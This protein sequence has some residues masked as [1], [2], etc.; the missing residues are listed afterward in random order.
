MPTAAEAAVTG[1]ERGQDGVAA[2][3]LLAHAWLERGQPAAAA[4]HVERIAAQ[5][6]EHPQVLRW[7]AFMSL[8]DGDIQGALTRMRQAAAQLQDKSLNRE[9]ELLAS[10][11]GEP[12]PAPDLPDLPDQPGGKLRLSGRWTRSHHRSGWR[13]ATEA[14]HGLHH[15]D[16][17]LFEGFLEQ[18]FAWEHP[19]AGIRP[20]PEL[21]AAL[22][23][24]NGPDRLTSEEL[25]RVPYREPWVGVLHNPPAMPNWFHPKEAPQTI[26]AK[27]IW[28]DSLEHCIGL[29][30]LS[31][32][33]ADWLRE[34]TG[35]PVSALLHPTET[36]ALR[37]DF[38]RFVAN[39]NKRVVQI[40]WWLR[41]L[42]AIDRLPLA[43]NNALGYR[44]LRLL[45]AFFSGSDDYLAGLHAA[46]IQRDGAPDA[47][48]SDNTAQR[49][50][51]PNDAY[52]ALLAGNIAFVDLYDA[53]ANNAVIECLVRG[54]PLLVNPL[55][56]VREYLGDGYPLY[57]QDLEQAATLAL[58]LGRLRAAHQYLLQRA[59]EL[60]L[61]AAS[62]RRSVEDSEVYQLL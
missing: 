45:P 50:H 4:R 33:A 18:A 9:A 2:A 5:Y 11:A 15:R 1:G 29:F 31:Q 49:R 38:E 7:R 19:R 48:Y 17:V 37:F 23:H 61:D 53:S 30:T 3:L 40:G 57:Y 42:S 14:L 34:T 43:A 26:L 20:G 47:R 62:F 8:H 59:A 41:R 13:Y 44:K 27:P 16:G 28:R 46:E 60:P 24:S 58:D 55:P 52:D 25:R 12:V 56:A 51:L 35:K 39:P 21:L 6:P 22:R 32:Y 54:T 10:L 36:P